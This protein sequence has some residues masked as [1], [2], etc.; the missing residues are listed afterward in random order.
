[1]NPDTF[2]SP[3]RALLLDSDLSAR[4][5][6]ALD[7]ALL[8]ARQWQARLVVATV[9]ENDPGKSLADDVLGTADSQRPSARQRAVR[10]LLRD[11]GELEELPPLTVRVER[12]QV[13]RT[14]LQ[15]ARGESCGLIVTGLARDTLFEPQVLVSSVA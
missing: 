13:D 3:P 11:L 8:L 7:R 5:D 10:R 12:G 9:V 6:R 14:L 15:V 1:M 2:A 4:C